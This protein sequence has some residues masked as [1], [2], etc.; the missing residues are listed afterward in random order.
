MNYKLTKRDKMLLD[1]HRAL[2]HAFEQ[3]CAA[4]RLH[5]KMAKDALKEFGSHGPD[6]SGCVR[7]HFPEHVKN[8]LRDLAR[9]ASA[10]V[11]RPKYMRLATL[12]HIGRLIATLSGSGFYGPVPYN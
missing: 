3:I 7:D 9:K 8:Q 10:S 5:S 2:C 12:N 1:K 11:N 6:I 4:S